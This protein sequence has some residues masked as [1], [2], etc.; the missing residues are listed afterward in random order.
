MVH[1]LR[2]LAVWLWAA[3]AVAQD[4]AFEQL[5]LRVSSLR[6]NGACIVDRGRR[7]LVRVGD[8]VVLL[9]TCYLAL[10]DRAGAQATERRRGWL[11]E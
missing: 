4:P 11:G 5:P 10:R 3:V 2:L 1:H 7:D 9:D 6:P 8:R